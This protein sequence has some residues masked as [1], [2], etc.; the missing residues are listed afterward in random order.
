[1]SDTSPI[2]ISPTESLKW[3]FGTTA[4]VVNETTRDFSE[5]DSLFQPPP[6]GNCA[7]WILGHILHSRM[8]LLRMLGETP[9]WD[10]TKGTQY[11]RGTAGI[12]AES[13]ALPYPELLA[14]YNETQGALLAAFDKAGD[15]GLSQVS[16]DKTLFD[17]M[18]FFHFHEAYHS[19]QLSIIRRLVGKEG[20]IK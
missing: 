17:H 12:D 20:V 10:E 1:M 14:T 8:S 9:P 6:S 11:A 18:L 5:Q 15:A 13:N 3:L 2:R 4:W 19:G 7:N 16:K